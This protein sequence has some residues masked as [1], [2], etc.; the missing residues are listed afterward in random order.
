MDQETIDVDS[1]NVCCDG[2]DS[3]NGHPKIYLKIDKRKGFII[4]PYCSKKFT[5]KIE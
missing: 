1:T 4:C 3:N 5:L 2:G